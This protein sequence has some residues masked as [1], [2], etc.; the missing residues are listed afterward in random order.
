MINDCTFCTIIKGATLIT[1]T[2][3]NKP[4]EKR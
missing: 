1:F 4:E 3:V 2:Y